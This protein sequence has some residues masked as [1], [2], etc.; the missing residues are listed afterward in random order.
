M[1]PIEVGV[2]AEDELVDECDYGLAEE[3]VEWYLTRETAISVAKSNAED[4]INFYKNRLRN[5]E[6]C[7]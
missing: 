7:Y 5:I 4:K 6:N 2:N 1:E 3:L